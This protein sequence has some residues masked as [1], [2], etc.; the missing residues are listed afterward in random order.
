[1]RMVLASL[2][3]VA[4]KNGPI[5]PTDPLPDCTIGWADRDGDGFGD[6]LLQTSDCQ[7]PIAENDL[8]CD[9]LLTAVNPDAVEVC[10]S[11]DNDCDELVDL[12]DPDVDARQWPDNDDDGHGAGE[13]VSDC[14]LIT[15]YAFSGDDCDDTNNRIYPGNNEVCDDL[16]NDC[17]ELVDD[18]DPDVDPNSFATF[19]QDL[20]ADGFGTPTEVYACERPDLAS[21]NDNDCDDNDETAYPGA[22]EVCDDVDDDCDGVVDGFFGGGDLCVGLENSY[23]GD[24]T[25]AVTLGG[26]T[27]TCDGTID[28]TIDRAQSPVLQGSFTCTLDAA[29]GSF[30]LTQSGIV[31]GWIDVD[32]NAGGDITAFQGTS[33]TWEGSVSNTTQTGFGDGLQI[34][35]ADSWNLDF[36]WSTTLVD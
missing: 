17:D 1:M 7:E 26:T 36:G 15:G 24:Y 19:F 35:G 9:D 6:P 23:S 18:D 2:W 8:D 27:R 13:P 34:D 22:P 11:I 21:D 31:E 20:D 25:A 5:V 14:D 16:D 4:C 33:R 32:G 28:I 3:L 10:D 29:A 12:D 30:D